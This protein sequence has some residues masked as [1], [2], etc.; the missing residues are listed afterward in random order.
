MQPHTHHLRTAIAALALIVT[1]AMATSLIA[2][3]AAL[4]QIDVYRGGEDGYHTYRIP[5]LLVT[6]R[7]TILAFCEGRKDGPGD[8]GNLDLVV[9]RSV[10]GG[11]TWSAQEVVYEQG[12]DQPITI[13]NPCP[14]I[15]QQSGTIW[16]PFC[17]NNDAVLVTS[18]NDDGQTWSAP[19]D[20][21]KDVKQPTWGWYA[22]GPGVG[23]QMRSP[24]Y[25]HRLVIPCDHRERVDGRWIKM[26]HVFFSDDG[27]TSW[28]LGGTVAP[29]TDECQVVELP[30]GELL[31]NMR[32]YW[33][34]EGNHPERGG[35]RAVSRSSDGGQT[36]SELQFD[37][38]LIEPVC[39]A[40]LIRY[41]IPNGNDWLVF[42][43]PASTT[44]RARL[45][46]RLSDD[47]G[48]HW[49]YQRLIY[50]GP[51]AYSC[52]AVMPNGEIGILY[53]RNGSERITFTRLSLTDIVSSP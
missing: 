41:S 7:G 2:Q 4:P 22:T 6:Q 37:E 18:S 33:Q 43:N 53:E 32:N 40:G 20:I 38:T 30:D 34:R 11:Q 36:W 25:A 47:E 9:K 14:V 10:D 31:I 48:K 49:P 1:W 35:K 24:K 12:G 42:T 5:S 8:H 19:R 21:T 52:P 45:T 23:I 27:G 50:E 39:Q 46:L 28:Q 3:P 13:G 17:R 44:R 51:S 16:L 26:S 29:H 15:D